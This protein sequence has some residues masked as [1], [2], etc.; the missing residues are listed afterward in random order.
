LR[1]IP[2]ER[3]LTAL[4]HTA[5][6]L[7]DAAFANQTAAALAEVFAPKLA[8]ARQLD[9][10]TRGLGTLK[11]FVLFS[12][13]S[14]VLGSAGQANYAA[15]NA[16]LDALALQRRA[17]GLPATSLA[18]GPW[19]EVGMATTLAAASRARLSRLG[20]Q[21]LPVAQGLRLLDAALAG[22]AA[23]LCPIQL[24][25]GG[26][27]ADR[28]QLSPL[29]AELIGRAAPARAAPA[30]NGAAVTNGGAAAHDSL[31]ELQGSNTE[32]RQLRITQLVCG[33]IAKV[34]GLESAHELSLDAPLQGLGLDSLLAV[35]LRDRLSA[36][37]HKELPATLVFDYPT[38]KAIAGLLLQLLEANGN[39]AAHHG[40][41]ANG[42]PRWTHE[43]IRLRLSEVPIAL[44]EQTGLLDVVMHGVEPERE[45][46]AVAPEDAI[47]MFEEVQNVKDDSLLVFAESML[48]G[49]L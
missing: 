2:G 11:H 41:G 6:V 46:A 12:S 29:L 22:S 21:Y 10:L 26:L 42:K 32:E 45:R 14:G 43:Q 49:E 5:G 13:V 47:D 23:V 19:D 35:E 40:N 1:R 44:L 7:R 9:Q 28:R 3:P 48:R 37:M 24:D 15:A 36:R 30:A 31:R 17:L 25:A 4:F 18:W 34:L 38:P 39:G 33:E 8:A 27:T 16:A 20:I